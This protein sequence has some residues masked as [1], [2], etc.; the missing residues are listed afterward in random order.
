MQIESLGLQLSIEKGDDQWEAD[1]LASYHRYTKY[2]DPKSDHVFDAFEWENIQR[3]FIMCLIK[4]CESPWLL[5]LHKILYDQTARYRAIT[6]NTKIENPKEL[7]ST[8][9]DKKALIDAIL[10]RDQEK[11]LHIFKTSWETII[12]F[13]ED[14]FSETKTI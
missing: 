2:V 8:C 4:A 10:E 11:S 6:V 12:G 1:L 13:L 7:F 9:V 3:E 5:R 14:T